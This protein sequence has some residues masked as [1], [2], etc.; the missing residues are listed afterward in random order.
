MP[1]E[2]SKKPGRRILGTLVASLGKVSVQAELR[3]VSQALDGP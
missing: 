3:I 1:R 2:V